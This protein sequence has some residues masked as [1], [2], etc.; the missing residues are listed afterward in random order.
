MHAQ[1]HSLRGGGQRHFPPV[2]TFLSFPS[3]HFPPVWLFETIKANSHF[4]A[5]LF[6]PALSGSMSTGE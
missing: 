6:L 1:S 2:I 5:K 4:N 3:C